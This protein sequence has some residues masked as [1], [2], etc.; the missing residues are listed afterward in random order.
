MIGLIKTADPPTP[1]SLD[2]KIP[3]DLETIILKAIDKDPKSRYASAKEM[4]ADLQ[5]FIDDVPIKG[6]RASV[7]ERLVRW[8]RR[9]RSLAASLLGVATLLAVLAVVS[10]AAWFRESGLRKVAEQ[11]GDEISR[12]RGEIERN[13]DEIERNRGEIKRQ[14]YFTEMNLSGQSAAEPYGADTIKARLSTWLPDQDV[15]H[16][17]W[18]WYYLHS[19]AHREHFAPEKLGGW[20]WSVDFSPD[21]KQFAAAVNGYGFHIYGT[22]TGR[23]I[24]EK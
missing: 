1:R 14:L 24:R 11:R 21:G 2:A 5:R 3:H 19:L 18:E 12:N 6:R 8:A 9:N 22:A 15:D 16:R 20:I 13:R 17:G 7:P 23:L 10:T 4:A